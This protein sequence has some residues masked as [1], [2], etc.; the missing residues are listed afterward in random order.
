MGSEAEGQLQIIIPCM[1]EPA[2]F[3]TTLESLSQQSFQDF[4]ITALSP[5]REVKQV[6]EALKVFDSKDVLVRPRKQSLTS[7]LNESSRPEE[8]SHLLFLNDDIVLEDRSMIEKLLRTLENPG[9]GVVGPVSVKYSAHTVNSAGFYLG[10]FEAINLHQGEDV[11][12]LSGL[13]EVDALEGAALMVDS[14]A[15]AYTE[16]FPE[17]YFMYQDDFELCRRISEAGYR[18]ICDRDTYLL[19]H[20]DIKDDLERSSYY[21]ARNKFLMARDRYSKAGYYLFAFFNLFFYYPYSFARIIR[22]Y[23]NRRIPYIM[24]GLIDGLEGREYRRY[25]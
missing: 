3:Q 15:F 14:E 4:H 23:E 2:E 1:N 8:Y 25:R 22:Y 5:E 21:S 18:I 13:S 11:E 10:A 9:V 12:D 20:L 6:K 7:M 24:K 16:G 19:H 17:E